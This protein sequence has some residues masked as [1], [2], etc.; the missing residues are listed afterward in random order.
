MLALAIFHKLKDPARAARIAA[1]RAGSLCVVRLPPQTA[2]VVV[3]AR[4]G[5]VPH[6]IEAAMRQGG[7]R[8]AEVH[9]GHLDEWVGYFRRS[10]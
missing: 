6:D 2:P 3:D 5:H 1:E 8:L 9:R 4:S 7:L 10:A